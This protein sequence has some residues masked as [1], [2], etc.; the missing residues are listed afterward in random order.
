MASNLRA[1]ASNLR[2]L[3]SN[4]R[5][6]ASNL[7]AMVSNLRAMASDQKSDG[8][9]PRRKGRAIGDRAAA[10]SCRRLLSAAQGIHVQSS[11]PA[12]NKVEV[13]L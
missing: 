10:K 5:A 6:M 12:V 11:R 1:M 4:L 3:A 7:R 9:Q 2:A 13:V 8:L